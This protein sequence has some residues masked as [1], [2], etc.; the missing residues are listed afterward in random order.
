MDY[1]N[2]NDA[3]LKDN[4]PLPRINQIVDDATAGHEL[5]SFLD[6]YSGYNQISMYP[7]DEPKTAFITPYD[8]Y[9]Y[10]VMSFGLKNV[11]VTYQRM[12]SRVFEPLLGKTMEVYIDDILVKSRPRKDH[13]A[14]LREAFCLLW[15][16]QLRLNLAKCAFAVS[17]SNFLG[18]LVFQRGIE[19]ALG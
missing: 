5:L 13:L 4:F 11:G 18:F 1:T 17:S 10:K 3:C 15:Q 2:L 14:H 7:P 8:M 12:M 6:A 16:Y 9:C 19:M